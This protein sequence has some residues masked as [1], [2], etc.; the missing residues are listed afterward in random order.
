M[1][2]PTMKKVGSLC[3]MRKG[4]PNEIFRAEFQELVNQKYNK[5]SRIYIIRSNKEEKA[6]YVVVTDQ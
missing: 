5:H 4:T 6:G 3:K 1:D 2:K